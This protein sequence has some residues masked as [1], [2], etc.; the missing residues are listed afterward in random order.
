MHTLN[1]KVIRNGLF[2]VKKV[3]YKQTPEIKDVI[4][5]LSDKYKTLELNKF[6]SKIYSNLNDNSSI[7]DVLKLAY[8]Y[9]FYLTTII[10]QNFE[11]ITQ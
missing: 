4:Q 8:S 7:Y 10:I 9:Y 11:D 2:R 5:N 6:Y 1:K 3:S